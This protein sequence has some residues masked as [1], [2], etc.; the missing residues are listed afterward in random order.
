MKTKAKLPRPRLYLAY[1]S[2]LNKA[3]MARRCPDAKPVGWLMLDDARLVFR[4]VADVIYAPGHQVPCG[5]WKI[6][7]RDEMALD[8]YE[9][10][11]A[12]FYSKH[13]LDIGRGEKALIYMMT[14]YGIAPPSVSYVE[15]VREGYQ[16]F[17]FDE[18]FLEGAVAHAF[19]E[20]EHS[21]Q[22]LERRSRPGHRTVAMPEWLALKRL[23][24]R[25]VL[26]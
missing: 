1:G 15:R 3:E 13:E 10:V 25:R 11:A 24:Q 9:G 12:G 5:I 16:D 7:R 6:S 26:S 4:G 23:E 17:G 8:R 22:T 14:D 20:K 21:E 18:N 19:K 2:N